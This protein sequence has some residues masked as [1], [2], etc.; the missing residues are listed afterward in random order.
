MKARALPAVLEQR[1]G[2]VQR[3]DQAGAQWF[4]VTGEV[5]INDVGAAV[6]DVLFPVFFVDKPRFSFGSELGPG[7]PYVAGSM[8]TC[9]ITV[10][11]WDTRA[12]PDGTFVFAGATLCIVSAGTQGQ[13]MTAFWH[14]EGVALRGPSQPSS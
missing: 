10:L 1:R 12:R 6:V 3:V 4:H 2:E 14:M 11:N 8:P 13:S 5:D 9:T 7:E